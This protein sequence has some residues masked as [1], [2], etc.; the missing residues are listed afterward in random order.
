[1]R[2]AAAVGFIAVVTAGALYFG[3]RPTRLRGHVIAA[4]L[5]ASFGDKGIVKMECQDSIIGTEGTRFVCRVHGAD[6]SSA[7][8][9]YTMDRTGHI[10]G[11]PFGDAEHPEAA[12]P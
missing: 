6:G 12:A 10:K 9:L 1:M 3:T 2:T 5:V 8:V 4:D 11:R 7:T